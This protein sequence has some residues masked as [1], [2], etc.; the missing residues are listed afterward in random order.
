MTVHLS[1]NIRHHRKALGL[2]QEQ[3]AEAMG[4]TVGAVSKWESGASTP[5]ITLIMELA[6]FFETSVDVLL[7]FERQS[8]TLE[9]T[10]QQLHELCVQKEFHTA[11]RISEKSLQKYP[12]SFPV[13]YECAMLHYLFGLEKKNNDAFHRSQ[14][15]FSRALELID[16]NQDPDISPVSIRNFIAQCYL[17]RGDSAKALELLK[18]NNIEG[19]NSGVIGIELAKDKD[20]C[21]E[22]LRHLTKALLLADNL[23]IEFCSGFV[24]ACFHLGRFQ[25]ALDFTQLLLQFESGLKK[26]RKTSYHDKIHPLLL[27]LCACASWKLGDPAG[28]KTHLRSARERALFFDESPDYTANN[29]NYTSF[30]KTAA[31]YD[32]LGPTAWEALMHLMEENREEFPQLLDLWEELNHEEA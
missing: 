24:N 29:L 16:Q 22:A 26:P 12:N 21:Q 3:L 30:D 4:V 28:A 18:A 25:E 2:T 23:L 1:E 13:V 17:S 7:G 11:F 8:G 20:T 10:V 15:L 9:S 5:E 32:N 19:I 14:E 6:E 31:A 27:Y